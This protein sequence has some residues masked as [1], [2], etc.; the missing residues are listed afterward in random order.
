MRLRLA[1]TAPPPGPHEKKRREHGRHVPT[2]PGVAGAPTSAS[3]CGR[4]RRAGVGVCA[5]VARARALEPSPQRSPLLGG[6]RFRPGHRGGF[7]M[8]A[9][10]IGAAQS[11]CRSVRPSRWTVKYAVLSLRASQSARSS[12][13]SA[14]LGPAHH[15]SASTRCPARACTSPRRARSSS[16][17]R[18]RSED[19]G[20]K[21][22]TG[23]C[24]S[25]VAPHG[26]RTARRSLGGREPPRPARVHERDATREEV[27]LASSW[28][29]ASVRGGTRCRRA[30]RARARGGSTKSVLTN[31]RTARRPR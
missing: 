29:T 16:F 1:P 15:R 18:R 14:S 9:L 17:V 12:P 4:A 21:H 7:G 10:V 6:F 28:S 8:G 30:R 3:P 25:R 23:R 13:R 22:P 31:A 19:R 27:L 20:A 11:T 2:E 24:G 26:F 5:G